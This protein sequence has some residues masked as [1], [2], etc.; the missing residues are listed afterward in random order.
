MT[1]VCDDPM[2]DALALA[3][4]IAKVSPDAVAASK[5]L[6]NKTY[7]LNDRDVR[8]TQCQHPLHPGP[9][10]ARPHTHTRTHSHCSS[11]FVRACLHVC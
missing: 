6:Y 11:A 7:A 5:R 9:T 10:P 1:K 2:A 8:D 3:K 4:D